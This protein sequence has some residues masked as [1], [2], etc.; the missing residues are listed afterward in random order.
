MKLKN[1]AYR[2]GFYKEAES[3]GLSKED[4]VQLMIPEFT[5]DPMIEKSAQGWNPFSLVTKPFSALAGAAGQLGGAALKGG[6]QLLNTL[7]TA[8]LIG[9]PLASLGTGAALALTKRRILDRQTETARASRELG[10]QVRKA[11]E[12]KKKRKIV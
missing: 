11:Q 3:W 9:V 7:L 12:D 5:V 10:E 6:S 1:K 4:V 2:E 8:A